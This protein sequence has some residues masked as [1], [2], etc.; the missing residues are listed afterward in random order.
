MSNRQVELALISLVPTYGSDLPPSLVEL[1]GSLLAQSR[2]LASTLKAEEEVAR[3]YACAH[4]ACDRLKLTLDLPPLAP[5]PP[6]PPRLYKRLHAHLDRV[7]PKDAGNERRTRTP[8]SKLRGAGSSPKARDLPSRPTPSMEAA[9]SQYRKEPNTRTRT[10]V[11]ARVQGHA[12]VQESPL[13]PWV[14]PVIRHLCTQSGTKKLAPSM[15]AGMESIL[16]QGGSR[17]TDD[18]AIRN[19]TALCAAIILFVAMRVRNLVPEQ[20]VDPE[21]IRPARGEII[22]QLAQARQEVPTSG[23]REETFWE[24]WTDIRV[25]EFDKAV[26]EVRQRG[27]LDADWYHDIAGVMQFDQ[28]GLSETEEA[29]SATQIRNRRADTMFQ[30]QYDLLSEAERADYATWRA[31]VMARIAEKLTTLAANE[32]ADC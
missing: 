18:W 1:A 30:D 8:R 27:W 15:L 4:I 21:V 22:D 2:H 31:N 10:P 3:L 11:K 24:G 14:Q 23:M 9:L 19:A 20:A 13:Y 28:A 25:Q 26:A 32:S 16:L 17:T 7:L 12:N 6:I 29:D 5:R